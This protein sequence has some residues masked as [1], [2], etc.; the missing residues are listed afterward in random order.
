MP[1]V[2][3]REEQLAHGR[4]DLDEVGVVEDQ[5]QAAHHDDQRHGDYAEHGD[6]PLQPPAQRDTEHGRGHHRGGRG[7]EAPQPVD[8]EEHGDGR[9]LGLHRAVEITFAKTHDPSRGR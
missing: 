4:L 3:E 1:T 6:A 7:H 9:K 2:G 5:G 8:Q